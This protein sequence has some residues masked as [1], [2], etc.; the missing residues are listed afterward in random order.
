MPFPFIPHEPLL[1]RFGTILLAAVVVMAGA[2]VLPP[3]RWSP[4]AAAAADDDGGGNSGHGGGSGGEGHGDGGGS[5]DDSGSGNSGPGGGDDDNDDG[6][7]AGDDGGS[8]SGGAAER[9][10]NDYIRGEVVVA[11]LSSRTKRE[12]G[13][14]GFVIIEE[15]PFAALGLTVARLRVPPRMATPAARTLLAARYP[16]LLVDL[17]ALYRPQG[18]LVLPAPDYAQ[19]L[20][21]W[22]QAVA[23]C[24]AGLRI[25]VLDTAVD[26]DIPALQGAKILQRSFISGNAQ[27]P[28][29]EHG[30]AVAAILVG[31]AAAGGYGLLPGAELDVGEVFAK[32]AAGK[33]VA[34]VLALVGGLNWLAEQDM[35][36]INLSLAGDANALVALALRRAAARRIVVV[37]AA[38]N[39]G[40]EAPPAFPASE[41]SV[42]GVT[43][44]DSRSQPYAAANRGDYVDF[45]APG[46]RIWTPGV[47]PEGSY[48]SGTSFAAP[49]VTAAIGALIARERVVDPD[50]VTTMLAATA[51]DLGSPGKDPV[52]GWGLIQSANP[53]V[54]LTQQPRRYSISSE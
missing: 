34:E 7:E 33:P 1:R 29:A 19:R 4:I 53:C 26:S 45:A 27:H 36:V 14:L 12:I 52:F 51:I 8:A 16:E 24:G 38:G 23:G 47:D 40:P 42:I 2:A 48:V 37:A 30:T 35:P 11:N 46:V 49:Y 15:R 9:D 25:G 10:G 50:R 32:D 18:Q 43:A 39:G 13:R 17:N 41:P 28:G 3:S 22:G 21:G 31:Q 6:D 44:L 5:G 54:A 20:I